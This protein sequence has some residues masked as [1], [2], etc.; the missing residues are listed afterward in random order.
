M[1][2]N[3]TYLNVLAS[4][5]YLGNNKDFADLCFSLHRKGVI[6]L[7]IDSG[8][9]TLHNAKADR[10]WLTVDNICKFL[11][12]HEDDCEKYVMLDVVGNA[13]QSKANYEIMVKRGLKPMFVLT[14]FDK[15]W[16]YLNSTL[17]INPNICVAG[18]V[19]TKGPW[20][21]KRFQEVWSKTNHKCKTHGL[22]YVTFPKMLQL[23]LA[24]VD[25]SSWKM[26]SSAYGY[27]IYFDKKPV[28]ILS[29]EIL[30]KRKVPKGLQ[31]VLNEVKFTP[32]QYAQKAYHHGNNSIDWL[33]SI[34]AYIKYQKYCYRH[35]L[36]LFLAV[37]S[38]IDLKRIVYVDQHLHNL[39]YDNYIK[40]K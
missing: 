5:A 36:R 14:M 20:M 16:D 38:A 23:P 10:S 7:M 35:G 25:S 11:E 13:A 15:D 37:G 18:G 40:V 33:L 1:K 4:Y 29:S 12:E 2:S 9:F 6:N 34:I 26:Q 19:T 21:T 30:K 17:D 8:A 24:S 32:Q 39:T 31:Q 22:G 28:A 3:N 27:S